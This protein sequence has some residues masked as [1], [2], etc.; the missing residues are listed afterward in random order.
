M[1]RGKLGKSFGRL[2][3]EA[4]TIRSGKLLKGREDLAFWIKDMLIFWTVDGV[5]LIFFSLYLS[6][7]RRP[8]VYF[9]LV[10]PK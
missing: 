3:I 4:V 10:I 7:I 2:R 1:G 5:S 8:Y 9:D 6:I